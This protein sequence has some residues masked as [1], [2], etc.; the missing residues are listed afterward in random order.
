MGF[1]DDVVLLAD[2]AVNFQHII[3]HTIVF[4]REWAMTLTNAKSHTVAVFGHR[5][6]TAVDACAT[7]NINDRY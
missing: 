1:T 5:D 7:F 4:L 2:T 6:K 3:D